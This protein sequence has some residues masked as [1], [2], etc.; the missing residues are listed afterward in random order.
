MKALL[1]AYEEAVTAVAGWSSAN[2][3]CSIEMKRRIEFA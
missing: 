1:Q 3:E 2:Q